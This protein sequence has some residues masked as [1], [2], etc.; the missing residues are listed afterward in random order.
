MSSRRKP[1]P[2]TTGSR[3]CEDRLPP[4]AT[5]RFRGMG[6][7]F[8]R[9]DDGAHGASHQLI[10]PSGAGRKFVSIPAC[11]NILIFRN[12]RS[13]YGLLV[14]PRLKRG[15]RERHERGV[16]DAVDV[17]VL[18]DER[19]R[20]GRRSRVVPT[21]RRWRQVSRMLQR[22]A[23]GDG[24]KQALAHRGERGVSRKTIA[25]GRPE[26]SSPTPVD[27]AL[28]AR[29]FARGPT[30]AGEH[31][32]F[33]APSHSKGAKVSWHSSGETRREDA[34]SC[35]LGGHAPRMRGIQ[36]S[37]GV[38]AGAPASLEYWIARLRGR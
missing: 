6:P 25:Q 4:D 33:P 13:C 32:V 27:F 37:R 10:C 7:G 8:R 2:I 5:D 11:K 20:R 3:C 17:D 24:G 31:P 26:C 9:D 38:S 36:Y 35:S 15:D 1:G 30:G 28:L 23:R 21:P 16:R 18:T 19:R 34:V 12:I 22:S 29:L 14:P